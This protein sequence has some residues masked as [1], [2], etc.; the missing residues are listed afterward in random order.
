MELAGN[1]RWHVNDEDVCR[2]GGTGREGQIRGDRACIFGKSDRKRPLESSITFMT[3]FRLWVKL[4]DT[5]A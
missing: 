5:D 1:E 3:N 4:M 2:R